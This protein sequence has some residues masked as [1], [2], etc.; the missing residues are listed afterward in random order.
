M[1]VYCV[2]L[3]LC[4]LTI[5]FHLPVFRYYS[6]IYLSVMKYSL[7]P[8]QNHL[9]LFLFWRFTHII[10][11]KLFNCSTYLL[12]LFNFISQDFHIS[13]RSRVKQNSI[14]ITDFRTFYLTDFRG[15]FSYK[16]KVKYNLEI[17]LFFILTT[18]QRF[19][20]YLPGCDVSN[21]TIYIASV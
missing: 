2:F 14:P 21:N 8:S 7:L 19:I 1:D 3:F 12:H 13:S 9:S 20:F 6:R 10:K 4:V 17:I 16:L 15:Y 11:T 18:L 5:T